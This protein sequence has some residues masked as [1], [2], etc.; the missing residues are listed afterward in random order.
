MSN[1]AIFVIVEG[2]S[3]KNIKPYRTEQMSNIANIA[4][5]KLVCG[6]LWVCVKCDVDSVY[7]IG[8]IYASVIDEFV[9]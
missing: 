7:S 1:I 4:C 8:G 6:Q 2:I 5:G 9:R 3:K